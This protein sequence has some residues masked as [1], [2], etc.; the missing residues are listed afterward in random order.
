MTVSPRA[1]KVDGCTL[2]MAESLLRKAT[3]ELFGQAC[4]PGV[5]YYMRSLI[6]SPMQTS[7]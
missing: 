2:A 1:A 3:A 4:A 6:Q 7:I 5:P